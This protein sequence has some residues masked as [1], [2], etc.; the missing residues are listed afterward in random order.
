MGV[1]KTFFHYLI[2]VEIKCKYQHISGH[3]LKCN[4]FTETFCCH[5]ITLVNHAMPK[6]ESFN[7]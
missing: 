5:L 4:S 7:I 6:K 2:N 3:C 1:T